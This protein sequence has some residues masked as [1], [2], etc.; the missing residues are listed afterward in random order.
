MRVNYQT[1]QVN[2]LNIFYRL[3]GNQTSPTVSV[4]LWLKQEF[5]WK[6][7]LKRDG[8]VFFPPA[9]ARIPLMKDEK[10]EFWS[11]EPVARTHGRAAVPII[12]RSPSRTIRTFAI[13]SRKEWKDF[14]PVNP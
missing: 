8:D 9:H 3:A 4:S 13:C 2:A 10:T 5:S 7:H 1:A 6:P 14:L 11:H 12:G